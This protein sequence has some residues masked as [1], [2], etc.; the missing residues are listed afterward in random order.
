MDAQVPQS[1]AAPTRNSSEL[2][3]RSA[4]AAPTG[5]P[6]TSPEQ[7]SGTAAPIILRGLKDRTHS[8]EC[9]W[10]RLEHPDG[11]APSERGT[12]F[13]WNPPGFHP[14][15]VCGAPLGRVDRVEGEGHGMARSPR[16]SPRH[17]PPAQDLNFAG[18]LSLGRVGVM[19]AHVPQTTAAPTPC[20]LTPLPGCGPMGSVDRGCRDAQPPATR[21][22][23]SGIRG[24]S[25]QPPATMRTISRR[26]PGCRGRAGNS[27]GATASPLCST[28]TL[29][30]SS[31]WATRKDSRVQGPATVTSLPL[32]MS[33]TGAG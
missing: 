26:S 11:G 30:G 5:L 19:D 8:S 15:L 9:P 33:V 13:A 16:L 2:G 28:T 17:N 7:R 23:A 31:P 22:D 27:D 14:G 12:C 20:W 10:T 3:D 24:G 21:W 32:A 18:A 25:P 29:F 4:T 1:T 6:H